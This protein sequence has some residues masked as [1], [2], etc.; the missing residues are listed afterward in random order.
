MVEA[1]CRKARVKNTLAMVNALAKQP[2]RRAA[3]VQD[4]LAAFSARLIALQG[5]QGRRRR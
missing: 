4:G 2:L 3:N 5:R 1:P